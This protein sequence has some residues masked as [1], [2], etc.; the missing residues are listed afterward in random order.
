MVYKMK[1]SSSYDAVVAKRSRL[2]LKLF[3]KGQGMEE[4]DNFQFLN[5]VVSSDDINTV[6]YLTAI[7]LAGEYLGEVGDTFNKLR[8]LVIKAQYDFHRALLFLS[9]R[10]PN[11]N[12]K[13]FLE[14]L[15][16][17]LSVGTSLKDFLKIEFISY[18]SE[19]KKMVERGA[20]KI[21]LIVDMYA[22]LT[23]ASI[24]LFTTLLMVQGVFGF[25]DLNTVFSILLSVILANA[26]TS[27]YMVGK[28]I[29]VVTRLLHKGRNDVA[30]IIFVAYTVLVISIFTIV[31]LI[32]FSFAG[33]PLIGIFIVFASVGSLGYFIYR[34]R[35]RPVLSRVSEINATLPSILRTMADLLSA[36]GLHGAVDALAEGNWGGLTAPLKRLKARLVAGISTRSA[37]KMFFQESESEML[38]IHMGFFTLIQAIGLNVQKATEVLLESIAI[39]QDAVKKRTTLSGYARGLILP[40]HAAFVGVSVIVSE[41]IK[42]FER[43]SSMAS[44]DQLGI[45]TPFFSHNIS[46]SFNW[47]PLIIVFSSIMILVNAYLVVKIEGGWFGPFAES[48]SQLML[49]TGIAGLLSYAASQNIMFMINPVGAGG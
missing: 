26:I 34:I 43:V 10:A 27:S 13:S 31:A 12:I 7:E 15:G 8:V 18:T 30:K 21:K 1:A 46:A 24:L 6:E 39:K 44:A 40:L 35:V 48:I 47:L 23:S 45:Q 32:A 17:A 42:L 28:A 38:R 25:A 29:P 5:G 41:L 49:V 9:K 36:G 22:A 3:A 2:P 16:R 4:Y 37:F 14:R 19:Q 33:F 20:E 11:R